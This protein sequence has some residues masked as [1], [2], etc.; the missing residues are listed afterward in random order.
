[1]TANLMQK[2]VKNTKKTI[3]KALSRDVFTNIKIE[4]IKE[5]I[6]KIGTDYG[7]WFIPQNILDKNSICYCV[8]AGE[9]ISFDIGLIARFDCHVFTFDP[10]PRAI[11]HIN[12]LKEKL[13][14]QEKMP[15]NN[16]ETEFYELSFH[17]LDKLNFEPI[18]L[19]NC[20]T[21]LKF[22]SP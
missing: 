1:M 10:T 21:V 9:D 19:W 3:F 12:T 20:D 4:P 14:K 15:I 2:V 17:Q 7:G 6:I 8:G 18:G 5:P 13:A 11:E 16:S 22:Y